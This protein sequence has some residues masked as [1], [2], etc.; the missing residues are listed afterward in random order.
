[1]LKV[2]KERREHVLV[3]RLMGKSNGKAGNPATTLE[4]RIKEDFISGN[5]VMVD[6]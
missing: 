5:T 3:K 2:P 6:G 4:Q 1:M